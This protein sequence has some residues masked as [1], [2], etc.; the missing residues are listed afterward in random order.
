MAAA[1]CFSQICGATFNSVSFLRAWCGIFGASLR[2]SWARL[3]CLPKLSLWRC[4]TT[5]CAPSKPPTSNA[6]RSLLHPCDPSFF[7][8]Q[9][10]HSRQGS[11][12]LQEF[13]FVLTSFRDFCIIFSLACIDASTSVP[14]PA[15]RDPNTFR[16][17]SRVSSMSIH[18]SHHVASSPTCFAP[19]SQLMVGVF[20][21]PLWSL[22]HFLCFYVFAASPASRTP[23]CACCLPHHSVRC[24]FASP[25]FC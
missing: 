21:Q 17:G 12:P 7:A 4:S 3:L 22:T 24:F 23:T 14:V 5:L 1:L 11:S 2:L 16:T 13:K 9:F 8:L 15:A 18:S 20:P 25:I 10:S 6:S 19:S